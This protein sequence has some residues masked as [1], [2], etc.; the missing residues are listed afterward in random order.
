[1]ETLFFVQVYRGHKSCFSLFEIVRLLVSA[2]YV[3]TFPCLVLAPQSVKHS[4]LLQILCLW[5]LSIVLFLS[6]TPSCLCFK[7]QR[8]G[9]WP[10]SIDWAQL[11][12]F[13]LKMETE[14]SLRNAVLK[15]KQDNILDKTWTRD[16]V[17]KHNIC[18]NVPSSQA[19]RSYVP[20]CSMRPCCHLG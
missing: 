4:P 2:R 3:K 19:F 8:F 13:Y 11:N 12:R 5:T 16:N 1:M 20:F 15:Y 18:T 7:T 6:K 14:S 10:S 9:D 17:Q